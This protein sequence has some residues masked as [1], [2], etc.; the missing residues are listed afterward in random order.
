MVTLRIELQVR[1]FDMWKGAFDKDAAGRERSGMR[2]YRIFRPVDDA[3]GVILDGDFETKKAAEGFLHIMRTEVWTS[4]D[5]APAKIG[6][7]KTRLLEVVEVK[8]Y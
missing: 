1:D 6:T 4:P 5:K 8:E 2:S 3:N 7:P